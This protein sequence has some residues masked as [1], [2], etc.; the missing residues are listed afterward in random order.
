MPKIDF[1]A[2]A[3]P[4]KPDRLPSTLEVIVATYGPVLSVQQ[5]MECL[6]IRRDLAYGL[7]SAGT[8]KSKRIGRVIRVPAT[9]VAEFLERAG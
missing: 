4:P 8:I 7:L 2:Y 6:D 1:K 9:A 5:L 3:R